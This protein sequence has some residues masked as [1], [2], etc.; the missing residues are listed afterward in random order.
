MLK[1]D[2]KVSA[3]F[4]VFQSFFFGKL[5]ISR[6]RM[7]VFEIGV[8]SLFISIQSAD[9]RKIFSIMLDLDP[10]M[11]GRQ[12]SNVFNLSVVIALQVEGPVTGSHSDLMDPYIS[13]CVFGLS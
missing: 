5:F 13:H 1:D 3:Y 7:H 12:C 8:V 4:I 10:G 9:I 2:L 6:Q 11:P